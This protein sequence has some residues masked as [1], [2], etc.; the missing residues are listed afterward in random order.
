M[1]KTRVTSGQ[2]QSPAAGWRQISIAPCAPGLCLSPHIPFLLFPHHCPILHATLIIF[3]LPQHTRGRSS[4]YKPALTVVF[5]FL[6]GGKGHRGRTRSQQSAASPLP[7]Y[8]TPLCTFA[9]SEGFIA[10]PVSQHSL[11]GVKSLPTDPGMHQA[12]KSSLQGEKKTAPEASPGLKRE[13]PEAGTSCACGCW[14]ADRKRRA[15]ASLQGVS[16]VGWG[17][18]KRKEKKESQTSGSRGLARR[19]SS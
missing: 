4:L 2:R 11:A 1:V 19:G 3:P 5:F 6:L 9:S 10:S 7:E 16:V 12:P 17:G 15:C 13:V 18:R 14:T 8:K